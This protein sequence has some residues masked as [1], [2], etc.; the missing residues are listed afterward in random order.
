MAT[1]RHTAPRHSKPRTEAAPGGGTP[2]TNPPKRGRSRASWIALGIIVFALVAA[3]G[4]GVVYFSQRFLPR[5]HIGDVDVSCMDAAE[6]HA[7]VK[8]AADGY[9][10]SL[11]NESFS[12]EVAGESVSLSVDEDG[13]AG[14]TGS[15]AWLWPA[16]LFPGAETSIDLPISYD[17]TALSQ[18]VTT[19]VDEHNAAYQP[20]GDSQ[21]AYFPLEEKFVPASYL[22]AEQIDADVAVETA[23]NAVESLAAE[24]EIA[25]RGS[26][27]PVEDID[28]AV[29]EAA[30]AANALLGCD[31][32]ITMGGSEVARIDG[33]LVSTW[34]AFD[35]SMAP[36]ID[37]AAVDEWSDELA[38]KLTTLG[39]ERTYT[40]PDGKT[41]TVD[42]G[43]E[44]EYG[45][46]VDSD[47]LA[48]AVRDAVQNRKTGEV[49]VPTTKQG[50]GYNAETGADWGAYVDVDITEQHARYYNADGELLWESGIITGNPNHGNDTPTGVY[51][52]NAKKEDIVLRGQI[53][54]ETGEPSYESPVSYWM[55]F[56]GNSYGLH[57]ASWQAKKSF[58]NPRAYLSTGSHGCVNLPPDA[59]EKLYGMVKVGDVVVVHK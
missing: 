13:V 30:D 19:A 17:E 46:V 33:E 5:T 59:A 55:A 57:D 9:V 43:E 8:D 54:P 34:V 20:I 45:W 1:G 15:P 42:A 18:L 38:G 26:Q 40:R 49:E 6:A 27:G 3:Y 14:A 4:A 32:S 50:T 39:A 23:R 12:L 25:T 11:S 10:L 36:S 56:I 47:A 16:S 37:T 44:S 2:P 58:E 52:L 29:Q 48:A 53:D 7:A 21:V 35:A 31:A 22:A 24:A 51:Q 28:P 41:V